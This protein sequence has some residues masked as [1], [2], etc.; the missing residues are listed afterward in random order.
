MKTIVV[1]LAAV[2][3][4][5]TAHAGSV[6][7]P[8]NQHF[9]A[10]ASSKDFH[11]AVGI[12]RLFSEAAQV[13]SAQNGWYAVVLGPTVE[14]SLKAF[15]ANYQGWPDVPGDAVWSKGKTYIDGAWIADP[16]TPQPK[17][18]NAAAPLLAEAGDFKVIATVNVSDEKQ[19]VAIAGS[20]GGNS[21]FSLATPLDYYSDFGATVRLGQLDP[22]TPQPETMVTQYTGGAHCC[23]ATWFAAQRDGNW[24][25][26]EGSQLDGGGYRLEDIDN[27]NSFELLNI[28]NSFLYAFEAYASSFATIRISHLRN[29]AILPVDRDDRWRERIRE[30][31]A[32]KEFLAKLNPDLWKSNGFLAPWVATKI[33]LGEGDAAWKKMLATYE[34]DN[35]FGPQVC[36]TGEPVESCAPEN[37]KAVPFPEALA[38]F[39][40]ANGYTPVPNGG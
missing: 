4:S 37:M 7:L 34:K 22:A 13:F 8:E 36:T 10:V 35:G 1:F 30:D 14:P 18:I 32:G 31:L 11:E 19:S 24:S 33:M 16:L 28:D 21:A 2:L 39:L 23:V 27:D 29:G 26:F 25:L 9:V 17:E 15:R 40:E 6:S 20:D 12:A 5:A 38:A 3:A